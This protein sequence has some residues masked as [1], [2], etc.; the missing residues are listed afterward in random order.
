ML[1]EAHEADGQR[2]LIW[3][4]FVNFVEHYCFENF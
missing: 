4:Y 3:L 1:P 2:A